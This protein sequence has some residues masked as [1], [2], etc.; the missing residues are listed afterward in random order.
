MGAVHWSDH[1]LGLVV[2]RNTQVCT[3][4]CRGNGRDANYDNVTN[5]ATKETAT[6]RYQRC[7]RRTPQ[8]PR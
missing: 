3:S 7:G 8:M 4:P 1:T 2:R 5:K 6:A